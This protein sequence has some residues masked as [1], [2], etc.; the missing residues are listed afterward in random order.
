VQERKLVTAL[1]CDYVGS[2]GLGERLDPEALRNVQ[3]SYFDRMGSVVQRFGGTLE[4]FIGDAVVAV[5]GVPLAHE[6][7]AERAVRCGLAMRDA[8][9]GLND[10]LRPR[11]GI[12]LDVRI[13]IATGEALVSGGEDALATGDVM[14]TAARLEQGA[15]PGE[16]LVA[17][18]TMQLSWDVIAFGSS[19]LLEARGKRE[20]LEAWAAEQVAPRGGRVRARLVGR[21]RELQV[22]AGAV[23]EAIR[24]ETTRVVVVLGEPG[25]GKT[26]VAEE[27]A[28]R[29]T[30]RALVYR[31]ACPPYGEG[32]AWLALAQVVQ[33]DT[34]IADDDSPEVALVRLRE[35]L[36]LRHPPAEAAVI[37]AQLAPLVGAARSPV[38]S[39]AEL[40]WA[41][42]RYLEALASRAPTVLVL[43]DLHWASENLLELIA[44]L[45][46]TI[47]AV[48]LVIVGQGRPELREQ[49]AGVVAS[50]HTQTL[51]VGPLS[52]EE[53]RRLAGSLNLDEAGVERAEGNPLFLEE[54]AAMASE[55][56]GTAVIPQ[57]L[58]ALI[59]AR[60]D[61]L[62]PEA[63]RAVQVGAVVGDVFWDAVVSTVLGTAVQNSVFRVL[64]TRGLVD[65]DVSSPFVGARQFR[66]HHALIREVAYESVS[67][68][69]RGE[70][71]QRVATWLE[72]RTAEH[73][74][75][76]VSVAHH[77]DRALSLTREVS[78]LEAPD[79]KLVEAAVAAQWRATEWAETNAA[80]SDSLHFARRAAALAESSPILRARFRARLASALVA[81]GVHDE[82]LG[83]AEEVLEEHPSD[84]ARAY[85]LVALAQVARDRSDPAGIRA[86]AEPA[87]ELA[88]ASRLDALEVR[89][90]TLLA[91]ADIAEGRHSDAEARMA[92][93]A[94]ICLRRGDLAG[95]GMAVG[96]AGVN[97][98]WRGALDQ[99][100]AHATVALRYGAESGSLRARGQT[101]SL[102]AHLRREQGR[103]EEA[104]EHGRERLRL[105]LEVG[106]T[107]KAVGACALT[108]AQP[109]LLLG[110]L[111]EAWQ[112]LEKGAQLAARIDATWFDDDIRAGRAQILRLQGRLAEAEAEAE[113]GATATSGAALL[114]QPA[115]ANE[116]A[117]I[118]ALQGRDDEAEGI[119]RALLERPT[120]EN[121]L[122]MAR[123]RIHLASFL[124]ER[125]RTGEAA[126]L[127]A[128]AR[129]AIEGSHAGLVESQ[130]DAVESLLVR[131]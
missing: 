38:A 109:L 30:G 77:L 64:R 131:G 91:W 45:V 52:L 9:E 79:P 107:F 10:S 97:A 40:L 58:R 126:E 11:L 111:D 122:Q 56:R 31:G 54:L 65:E 23:E 106:D 103:L 60:L 3:A 119:W 24:S 35:R 121:V 32:A 83:V 21:E 69:E 89:V 80:Q 43:D 67:K 124:T 82:G 108:L 81:S 25:I 2:T 100:E 14:N 57:S 128:E 70:L 85:A 26:R 130:L 102:L 101:Q 93:A 49:L 116:L 12:E 129:A 13:G 90:L 8:L 78:P 53:A 110:R 117:K 48:P 87:L 37:E 36:A 28:E 18:E 75:L 123:R 51:E 120:G 88:Q 47:A 27:F 92:L 86:H 118:H 115:S 61:L 16:I 41:L 42:R 68:Q 4:K 33:A 114:E 113:L 44:E 29:V 15:G 95:A 125:G 66:F 96:V 1:F 17:R 34:R 76:S 74:S 46:E 39:G 20:P 94:E 127:V 104:V 72:E 98:M 105:E 63:K 112:V 50:E 6:D 7:D 5:F 55:T 59:G 22:L 71:H 84:D 19:R 62:P 99:A 73:P